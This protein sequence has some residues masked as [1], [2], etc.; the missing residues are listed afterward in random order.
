MANETASMNA[1]DLPDPPAEFGLNAEGS[2]R[3]EERRDAAP[4]AA[5]PKA[6]P[7]RRPLFRN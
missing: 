4:V 7:G 5:G 1:K 2:A 3:Q 6:P